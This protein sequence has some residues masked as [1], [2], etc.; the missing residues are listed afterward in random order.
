MN[1]QELQQLSRARLREAKVL[2]DA[3]NFPGSYYLLGYAVECAIKAAI[4]KQ[5]RRYDFPDRD[6][7]KASYAHNLPSLMKTAALWNLLETA[8]AASPSLR[9]NWAV[10]K[11]WNSESR[12]TLQISEAQARDLYSACTA[13]TH[14][15][16]S[17]LKKYW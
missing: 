17:W 9:V 4:A 6:T 3:G 2:L 10:I 12:Y 5:V 13:R 16:L 11:D 8:M 15:L 1:R 7:V 14:G